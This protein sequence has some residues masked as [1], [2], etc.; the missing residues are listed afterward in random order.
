MKALRDA[1]KFDEELGYIEGALKRR[2]S[3]TSDWW[4]VDCVIEG[5]KVREVKNVCKTEGGVL[6][7]VFRHDWLLDDAG[8]DQVFQNILQVG[9]ISGW[10]VHQ[11]TMDRIFVNWGLLKIVLYDARAESPTYGKLNELCF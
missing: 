6:T 10:H 7:E 1:A 2:Q 5:V 9:E 3:V 8:V 4:P 11:F